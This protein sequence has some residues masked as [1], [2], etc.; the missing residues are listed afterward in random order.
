MYPYLFVSIFFSCPPHHFL[1]FTPITCRMSKQVSFHKGLTRRGKPTIRQRVVKPAKI[2]RPKRET[3]SPIPSG[4]RDPLESPGK[5]R[6]MDDMR[7]QDLGGSMYSPSPKCQKKSGKV[8]I[9]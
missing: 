7:S 1:S 4:S 2:V 9:Q 6:R 5:K 3:E 8:S